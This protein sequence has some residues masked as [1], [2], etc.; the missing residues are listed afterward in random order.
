MGHI[1]NATVSY[2][3]L[4]NLTEEH[5]AYADVRVRGN[6]TLPLLTA[7]EIGWAVLAS[8]SGIAPLILRGLLPAPVRVIEMRPPWPRGW[9]EYVC[10]YRAET[11]APIDTETLVRGSAK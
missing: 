1:I 5:P 4:Q 11:P 9:P 10:S 6:V 2:A 7:E 8:H 3:N